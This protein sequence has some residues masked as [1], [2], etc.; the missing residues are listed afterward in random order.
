[1]VDSLAR[2][3]F[4]DPRVARAKALMLEA[5]K[6]HQ[7]RISGVKPPDQALRAPYEE[8]LQEFGR[9][10][11][12]NLFYPYIGSGIGRGPL[13]ELADGSVKYDFISGIGVHHWGHSNP[14]LVEAALDAALRDTI[15]QGNLQ[16]NLESTELA[17]M[18]LDAARA[19]GAGL[20]HCFFSTSGA[21]ANENAL[22]IIFNERAP[23]DRLLAFD[24][25]FAGRTLGLSQVTDRPAYRA[26]LPAMLAVDYVPFFD[27]EQPGESIRAAMNRVKSHLA[28][29]PGRY[30]A[31]IFELVLG[32][33]GFLPGDRAFFISLME[34]LKENNITILLDEVQ[35]FGRTTQLFAFQHFQ[36]EEYVD[37]VTLGKLSQVCATLFRAEYAPPPGL[38][39]QTFTGSTSAIFAS[40]AMVKGMLEGGFFGSD[41]KNA[42][43][44]QHFAKRLSELEE[45]HPDLI[46][47]PFGLGT[48]IAFTP[49]GG[50]PA[51]TN[52][53]IHA[54]FDAGVIAFYCGADLSRV[55]FLVP[56]GAVTFDHIDEVMGIVEETL[57]GVAAAP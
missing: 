28:R 48:M 35:T 54:L 13:V 2:Q 12:G 26:G 40:R 44:H 1:M 42:R 23:A 9:I 34:V 38:L 56:A 46:E 29:Y 3:L 41:G 52:R 57:I 36:L 5:L 21:M 4:S 30:A 20:K 45:R 15:M 47:G 37:V 25:C 18:L 51:K 10:R 33:G 50:D 17:R 16:Q 31:M 39:S 19:T 32:E 49:F 8:V 24:G 7:G 27:P 11:A 55:R 53:F 22:K 14:V 6:D 43:L